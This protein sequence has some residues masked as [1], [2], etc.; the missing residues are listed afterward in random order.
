MISKTYQ[1]EGPQGKNGAGGVLETVISQAGLPL[2]E[3][4][5]CSKENMRG[6]GVVCLMIILRYM[7]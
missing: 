2:T 7:C 3:L 6:E 1:S 5:N 4:H